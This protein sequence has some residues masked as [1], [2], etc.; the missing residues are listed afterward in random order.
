MIA[1]KT[2]L[3]TGQVQGVG[4]RQTAWSIA[5]KFAV[6]GY[7]RNLRTGQVELVAQGDVAEVERYVDDLC[8]RMVDYIASRQDSDSPVCDYDDFEIRQ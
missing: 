6:V 7:V 8:Q 5:R 4:F 1:C 3:F 2:V